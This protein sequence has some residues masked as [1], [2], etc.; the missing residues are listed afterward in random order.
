M[1]VEWIAACLA[2]MAMLTLTES[3]TELTTLEARLL[4]PVGPAH[5]EEGEDIVTGVAVSYVADYFKTGTAAFFTVVSSD[6]GSKYVFTDLPEG[7]THKGHV[8]R[9]HA[10]VAFAPPAHASIAPMG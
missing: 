2:V 9:W 4:R 10:Q 3:T 8:V 1:S 5:L 6:S 7:E